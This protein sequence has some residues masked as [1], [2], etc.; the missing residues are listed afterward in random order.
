MSARIVKGM[1]VRLVRSPVTGG[2]CVMPDSVLA[3]EIG[4]VVDV[5]VTRVDGIVISEHATVQLP[6]HGRDVRRLF[7][8]ATHYLEPVE[9]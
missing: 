9:L 1:A 6:D 2:W 7:R 5:Q 3:S 8:F 4:T